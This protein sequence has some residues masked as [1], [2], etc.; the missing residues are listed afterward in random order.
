MT[1]WAR[2][3]RLIP[4]V[5]L[6]TVCLFAL[7][8][9]GLVFD[10]GYT[11]G[12]RLQGKHKSDL[13]ISTAESVP[14]YP[15]I[16]IANEKAA[17]TMPPSTRS[18]A[19][20]LFNYGNDPDITGSVGSAET[21]SG[22]SLKVTTKPPDPPKLEIG[23]L[24]V[25]M[26]AG[27]IASAG[28]RAILE[29]LQERR[30]ELDTRD[31]EMEMR[32]NL[33]KATEKRL[34]AKVNELKALEARVNAAITTRNKAEAQRFKSIVTMYESM[35]PK[36]AARILERLDMN[37][38]VEVATGI[39]PETMSSI[40]AQMKPEAAERL[41]LELARHANGKPQDPNQLP[42]IEGKPSGT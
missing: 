37:I 21:S 5:L 2:D 3:F 39:R 4:V 29:R 31:R 30:K 33:L 17:A 32:E 12:E 14:D 16:V 6:A 28:E 20:E 23:S 40:L 22:P 18:W 19:Q 11:L 24:K 10:G 36:D 9:S 38:L 34:E 7:K 41:T 1:R 8:V 15:K 25:K 13:K 27:H 26:E 35:K 42:K